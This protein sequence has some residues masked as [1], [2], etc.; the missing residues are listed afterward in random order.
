MLSFIKNLIKSPKHTKSPVRKA[1]LDIEKLEARETPAACSFQQIRYDGLEGMQYDDV[2][3][4]SYV[5]QDSKE[6]S[7][8]LYEVY[9]GNWR[10][11]KPELE[12]EGRTLVAK[13]SIDSH[14][15]G[16][17]RSWYSIV[18]KRDGK[19]MVNSIVTLNA[20]NAPVSAMGTQEVYGKSGEDTGRR[21]LATFFDSHH[22][23]AADGNFQAFITWGDGSRS[24]GEIVVSG[25]LG[26]VVQVFGSHT[27]SNKTNIGM[28]FNIEVTLLENNGGQWGAGSQFCSINRSVTDPDKNSVTVGGMAKATTYAIVAPNPWEQW[29]GAAQEQVLEAARTSWVSFTGDVKDS[30]RDLWKTLS[31]DATK[32]QK[33]LVQTVAAVLRR[34]PTA[35]SAVWNEIMT[36]AL[37]QMP[38]Q[39]GRMLDQVAFDI[40]L[41][42]LAGMM[43]QK[44]AGVNVKVAGITDFVMTNGVAGLTADAQKLAAPLAK[45]IPDATLLSRILTVNLK[46]VNPTFVA[47][48]PTDN[49]TLCAANLDDLLKSR[50][51]TAYSGSAAVMEYQGLELHFSYRL[52]RSVKFGATTTGKDMNLALAGLADG[53]TGVLRC[54]PTGTDTTGYLVN[55]IKMNGK[56]YVLDGKFGRMTTLNQSRSFQFIN[57]TV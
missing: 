27:Y 32:N 25:N 46:K 2:K 24:P 51:G 53:S 57:T 39:K 23:Y 50:T 52:G 29:F 18:R 4:A 55:V 42:K 49:G 16:P 11:P 37:K 6:I 21:L 26:N 48:K 35:N 12:L 43:Q 44:L 28:I 33:L 8:D 38:T 56:V 31:D 36:E 22:P 10:L 14:D 41:G 40:A 47:G 13:G 19:S 34:T 3:V 1:H 20:G 15:E 54:V 17:H 9:G 5:I 45:S 7:K 30:S